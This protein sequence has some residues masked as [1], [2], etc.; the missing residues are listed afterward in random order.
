M[1]YIRQQRACANGGGF[2]PNTRHVVYGLDADDH[3]G[4]NDA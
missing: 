2:D 1:H 3:V 4:I